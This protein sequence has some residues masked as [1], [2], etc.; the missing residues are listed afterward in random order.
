MFRLLAGDLV[1]GEMP[2][3]AYAFFG[4]PPV[5]RQYRKW[6]MRCC[7]WEIRRRAAAKKNWIIYIR[8]YP[9]KPSA[10]LYS[11]ILFIVVLYDNLMKM[12]KNYFI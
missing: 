9:V 3:F 4:P 7:V 11:L 10:K 5:P 2:R 6:L 8:S 12:L 1:T